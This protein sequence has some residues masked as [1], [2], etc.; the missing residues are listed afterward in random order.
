VVAC[1]SLLTP[2][3]SGPPTRTIDEFDAMVRTPAFP[4]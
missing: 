1:R 4:S 3:S 2:T